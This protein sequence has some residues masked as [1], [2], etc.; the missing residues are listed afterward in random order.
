VAV[1]PD[2]TSIGASPPSNPSPKRRR[3][4]WL[5]AMLLMFSGSL[6]SLGG[7]VTYDVLEHH[8]AANPPF[9]LS[10]PANAEQCFVTPD[11]ASPNH[12]VMSCPKATNDHD[13]PPAVREKL[14][15]L[16][17]LVN[18]RDLDRDL[19]EAQKTGMPPGKARESIDKAQDHVLDLLKK[20]ANCRD[21]VQPP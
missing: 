17:V 6:T 7:A 12:Y 19:K 2:K 14:E 3:R 5:S 15:K 8:N 11:V 1:P 9:V 16:D 20:L 21:D 4:G 18:L 10:L 13:C